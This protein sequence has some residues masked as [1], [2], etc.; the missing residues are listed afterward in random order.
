MDGITRRD[1]VR[2][3]L[4]LGASIAGAG[5]I[6][7]GCGTTSSA[8]RR[9]PLPD[10]PVY[11]RPAPDVVSHKPGWLDEWRRQRAGQGPVQGVIPRSAWTRQGPIVSRA[12]PMGGINRITVHHDGMT[13]FTA[14]SDAAASRR[15]EAIRAA[16][17]NGNGWAD[18]GY[19]YVIDPSG[20]VW[21]GRPLSLQGAH[22]GGENNRNNLGIV[23]LGNY[24]DQRPT[25][26]SI[27]SLDNFVAAQM[28]R[29][30]IPVSRVYTHQELKPTACPGRNLQAYME[31]TRSRGGTMARA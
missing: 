31:R 26:E 3:G 10:A 27:A 28:Q 7:G 5:I 6:L 18:I 11:D 20:R 24:D 25:N 13:P 22:A 2:S 21:E 15:I 12:D 17:V 4:V 29:Y 23:V 19:H 8:Q 16:H 30:R 1:I 14:T 9:R